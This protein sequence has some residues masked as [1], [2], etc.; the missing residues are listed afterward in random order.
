M[1]FVIIIGLAGFVIGLF[2]PTKYKGEVVL[3]R[4]IILC[5]RS[6]Y[7]SWLSS[8][9]PFT[10]SHQWYFDIVEKRIYGDL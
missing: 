3:A 6:N 8:N 10:G 4:F 2:I 5:R 7:F 9:V 1:D